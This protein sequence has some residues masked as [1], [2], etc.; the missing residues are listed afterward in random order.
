MRATTITTRE[1]I[2]L[3][4][5]NS[6]FIE[7]TVTNWSIGDLRIRIFI[8][9]RVAYGSDTKLV[10]QLLLKTAA[11]HPKVLP[12]PKPDVLFREF[13]DSSLNFALRVWIPDPA[14]RSVIASDLNHAIDAAFKENGIRVP[15]PQRDVHIYSS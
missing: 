3:I 6:K 1:N 15:F 13:G 10:E 2:T 7:D 11:E 8:S 5:P 9:V 4:V 12:D 14:S